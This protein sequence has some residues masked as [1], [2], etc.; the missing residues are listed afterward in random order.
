M[1][2]L[3]SK[4]IPFFLALLAVYI[5]IPV[6][7]LLIN[8]IDASQILLIAML[9]LLFPLA[10]IVIA[11]WDGV[12]NGFTMLW[13]LMPAVFFLIPMFIY[14]NESALIYSGI[15]SLF[16]FVANSIGACFHPKHTNKD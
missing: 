6:F 13:I 8:R 3:S 5:F 7:S 1:K 12:R 14:F 15:Y 11:A 16:A 2:I 9:L 10:S 4:R